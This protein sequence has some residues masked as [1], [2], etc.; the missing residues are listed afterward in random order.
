MLLQAS[1]DF[2]HAPYSGTASSGV[3]SIFDHTSPAFYNNPDSN[4][5]KITDFRGREAITNTMGVFYFPGDAK[6]VSS[7]SNGHSGYDYALEVGRPVLAAAD[8][9]NIL[10]AGWADVFDN[11]IEG[12]PVKF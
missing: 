9:N 11:I 10:E 1:S 3:T 2:L 4:P 7:N 5:N 12:H 8:S 6:P